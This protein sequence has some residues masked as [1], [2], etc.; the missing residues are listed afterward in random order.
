MLSGNVAVVSC[1]MSDSGR[2]DAQRW[3]L[4]SN[5]SSVRQE[6]VQRVVVKTG[7]P[8]KRP[9]LR[10]HKVAGQDLA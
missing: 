6:E 8:V 10:V 5:A 4:K 2:H 9:M 7:G 3:G 1:N